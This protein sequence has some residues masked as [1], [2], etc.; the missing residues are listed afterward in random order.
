M[1]NPRCAN[2]HEQPVTGTKFC[3]Y[4]GSPVVAAEGTQHSVSGQASEPQAPTNQSGPAAPIDQ[5]LRPPTVQHQP[6]VPQN[7]PNY[8]QQPQYSPV[9]ANRPPEPQ[10]P[11]CTTCGGAGAGLDQSKVI[12]RECRWLRPL[13]PGYHV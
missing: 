13:V 9:I 6:P 2:G 8:P 7:P 5:Q 3:I 1:A 12:C 10:R 11:T 4:C